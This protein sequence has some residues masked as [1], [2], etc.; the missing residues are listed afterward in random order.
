MKIAFV[1]IALVASLLFMPNNAQSSE[2][3]TIK[4]F[5]PW[6][7]DDDKTLSVS[8]IKLTPLSA[9]QLSSA[10]KALVG[11][12]TIEFNGSHTYVG[13]SEAL[14]A[15]SVHNTKIPFPKTI[16]LLHDDNENADIAIYIT[17]EKNPIYSGYTSNVIE[18]Q[19]IVKS[20]IIIY[21]INNLDDQQIS[22]IVRHEFG[23]ALGL[24]HSDFTTDLMFGTVPV[25]SYVSECHI[26]ALV[27]L[28]DGNIK[29]SSSCGV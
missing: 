16:S 26:D 28:Y 14:Q 3:M 9:D 19:K 10:K 5:L 7:S 12:G 2:L 13:W 20:N 18:N 22:S 6:E 27:E 17:D 11:Y 21:D 15:T 24:K 29:N 8:I 4:T 1:V 23:H 25:P